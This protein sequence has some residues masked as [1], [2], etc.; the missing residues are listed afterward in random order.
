M[1]GLFVLIF[2]SL[3]CFSQAQTYST[4]VPDEPIYSFLNW[5]VRFGPKH[6]K[7]SLFK[8]KQINNKIIQWPNFTELDEMSKFYYAPVFFP[9]HDTTPIFKVAD[10]KYLFQQ[11]DAK[12]DTLWREKFKH[13]KLVDSKKSQKAN[14]YNFSMPLFS[15]DGNYAIIEYSYYCGSVC[16]HGG[17][18]IYEKCGIRKWKLYKTVITWMS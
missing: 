12:Q 1:K 9:E 18:F 4:V 15:L 10:T 7:E 6:G 8:R 3:S 16:A 2:V 17:T 13:S 5:F 14:P 11:L